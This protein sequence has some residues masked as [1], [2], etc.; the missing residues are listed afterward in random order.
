MDEK[1]EIRLVNPT[2]DGFLQKIDWNKAELEAN[3]RS[4][5][6]AYRGLVYTEDTVSD[7]KNDRAALRKLLNEIEDRRKLV[8]KKCMEPY[9]VFESDL[10]DVTVLIKEQISIIDGQVKEYENSVK[11]EKKAR[12]QDVYT[13]AIGE[14]AELLPFERVFEAQYLNVSFKESKASTEIQE[15]IQRV[16]SDLAAIDALDSKYKLNAKDVYVRTL[17]MSQAMA[18]NA[19]LIKFEEQMEADR[20][21]KSEEEERRR[22]EAEAR[23]K[24]AEERRRQEAEKNAAE[25]AEREKALAEQQAQEERA[26]ESGYNAPVPDKTADVQSEE[27]AEKPAEKEVLPE[28]KKYKA[29]FYAIGTLQ[30]LKDLQEYMKE[31]NIQFGKAG[32]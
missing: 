24:E 25:R 19:R 27:P 2:E 7:A 12:L 4:I 32:K 21:R 17:D 20:K 23:A 22:A 18:E 15:K 3:V 29:T 14:L 1:M 31:H 16:K 11:E 26:S 6:E 5:V 30:Q 9:E 28:E 8:K 13:E 10:K